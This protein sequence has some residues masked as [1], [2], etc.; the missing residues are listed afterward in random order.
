MTAIYPTPPLPLRDV[1]VL[2]I[3]DEIAALEKWAD[4]ILDSPETSK[5]LRQ[6][7][8]AMM[9]SVG[10]YYGNADTKPAFPVLNLLDVWVTEQLALCITD[11]ALLTQRT[12]AGDTVTSMAMR[13]RLNRLV[14]WSLSMC[15]QI[16]D[17]PVPF[18]ERLVR[19]VLEPMTG[20]TVESIDHTGDFHNY[21]IPL[22]PPSCPV[23]NANGRHPREWMA[24]FIHLSLNFQRPVVVRGAV[25]TV[26]SPQMMSE[27]QDLTLLAGV[28]G[29]HASEIADI[30]YQANYTKSSPPQRE[31]LDAYERDYLSPSA[32]SSRSYFFTSVPIRRISFLDHLLEDAGFFE[33]RTDDPQIAVGPEGT[34]A[35]VHFH[36]PAFNFV[37][38]GQKKWVLWPPHKSVWCNRHVVDFLASRECR[39]HVDDV[40]EALEVVQQQGDILFVPGHWSHGVLNVD[41]LTIA[42]AQELIF[43]CFKHWEHPASVCAIHF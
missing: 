14:L 33:Y 29:G 28:L 25:P 37:F 20:L 9:Y 21:V 41:R 19:D 38:R 6:S 22:T 31:T 42:V 12:A 1:V 7:A 10:V 32:M 27:M 8:R 17:F 26:V 4:F 3:A 24:D 23:L 43:A 13:W 30:P 39:Q 36:R 16:L 5:A 2:S 15:P 34:G 40:G 18:S 11:Q 35:P